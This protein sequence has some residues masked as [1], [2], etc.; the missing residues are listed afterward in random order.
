MTGNTQTTFTLENWDGEITM[1]ENGAE[2]LPPRI[3]FRCEEND[4]S[5][6]EFHHYT[7]KGWTWD[8]DFNLGFNFQKSFHSKEKA[9][10]FF[11]ELKVKYPHSM[12]F[13]EEVSQTRLKTYL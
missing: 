3:T 6:V 13:M 4:E 12:I 8:F 7:V 11:R 1:Y 2:Y 5:E 9:D 10:I